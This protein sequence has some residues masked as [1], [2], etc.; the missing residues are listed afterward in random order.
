MHL[1]IFVCVSIMVGLSRQ[2]KI[3]CKIEQQACG[4]LSRAGVPR[5][6][7]FCQRPGETGQ[8]LQFPERAT[9]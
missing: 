3:F 7:W 5:A 9:V 4:N 2:R 6:C 8:C 1:G